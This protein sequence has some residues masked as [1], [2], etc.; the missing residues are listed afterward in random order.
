MNKTIEDRSHE[1][2]LKMLEGI[3]PMQLEKPTRDGL[4]YEAFELAE[5]MQAEAEKRKTTPNADHIRKVREA[6]WQ[7]DWGQA[8]EW[9]NYWFVTGMKEPFA[10]AYWSDTI[11]CYNDEKSQTSSGRKLKAPS[12]DYQGDWKDSLRK[13]P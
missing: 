4:A 1:I 2:L 13:R 6:Q 3:N 9:A 5:A 12:F 11:P 10:A 7:P 8:P